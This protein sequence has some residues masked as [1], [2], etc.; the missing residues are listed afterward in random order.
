VVAAPAF[1]L[2]LK[3]WCYPLVGCA[4]YRGFFDRQEADALAETLKSEGWEVQVYGVPAYST[5]GWSRWLG[6]DPLLNTFIGQ[7]EGELAAMMFHELAH[8]MAYAADDS[9]FNESYA[10]AVELLGA[11]RWLAQA[12]HE[13]AA[14]R[15]EAGR[16]R[17][18]EFL[19]L[20]MAQRAR[21]EQL[22]QQD[23]PPAQRAKAKVEAFAEMRAA[24]EQLRQARWGGWNGYAGWF[25][26]AN[27]ASLGLLATYHGLVPQFEAL[28]ERLG[29]DWARFH[30]EVKRL[31]ALPRE[32]RRAQLSG[33]VAP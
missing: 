7:A 9:E 12:G 19:D 23:L 18:R 25:Q 24:H 13:E 29:G 15:F 27:N 33:P 16:E 21:I 22:Y 32:S 4:G 20:V 2:Q 14:R 1:S 26:R 17:R 10:T 31:A 6:G 3:T 8:Q 11:R 28:F 5:L 30:A